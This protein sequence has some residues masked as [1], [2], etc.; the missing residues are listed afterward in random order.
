LQAAT[1]RSPIFSISLRGMPGR[2]LLD[3][4]LVAPLH[5]AVALAQVHRIAV[6]VGQDLDFDVARV[7][8]EFL[9]VHR[10]IA[11]RSTRLGL[12]HL[13]R[14]D[15]RRLGVHHAHAAPT[16]AAR[17]LDDDRIAHRLGDAADLHRVV[18]QFAFRA[19]HAGHAR[20]DHGLLGRHLVAHDAD[21]L[22]RGADELEPAF[23]HPLGKVG[24]F[25]QETIAGVDGLGVGH[26][27]RRDD[28][29]HVEVAQRRRRRA[30][31]D[32]LFGQLDVFGFAVG[33]GIDHHRLDAQFAAGALDAQAISP[34]L[35]TRIFLNMSGH[36]PRLDHK[37]RLAVFHGLAVLAQD[38][39]TVP[40]LS[41]S[42]SLRIFMASMMQMVSPSLTWL[43]T[44]TKGLA[45]GLDER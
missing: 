26:L 4:L 37:Q 34:R 18:G 40:D 41:A 36:L 1:Q 30:D 13:H 2:R 31:A 35:A 8:E 11:K 24:V 25:A 45:P 17:G 23:F 39:V 43:P 6:L 15:Q 33:L 9:H 27:G 14:I 19:R 10:R 20:L 28:G 29:R 44:S 42:I 22:G 38:L 3:H 5:G 16:A 7:L 21:G 32:G 12:G